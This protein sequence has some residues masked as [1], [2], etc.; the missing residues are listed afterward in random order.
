MKDFK[1]FSGSS[2]L[3][4]AQKVASGL[5]IELAKA[6]IDNFSNG[7][8]RVRIAEDV[9]GK[10]CV[11]LQSLSTPTDENLVET[12]FFLDALKRGGAKKIIG[13]LPWIGYQKQDKAFR[14]GEAVS[15]AV[16]IKTLET[17][18]LDKIIT[19]DLHSRQIVDY[20]QNKPVVLSAFEL[21]LNEIKKFTPSLSK[22]PQHL[23]MVAPDKGAYWQKEFSQK[24]K[25][26]LVTVTKERNKKTSRIAF[27][28]LKIKGSVKDK[29]CI[30][31]DDNLYTGS[32]LILNAKLLKQKGAAAVLCF[33]THPILSGNAPQ[34]LQNSEIDSLT[35]S[36]TIFVP[37][38][39]RFA[40]LK[41][42]PVHKLLVDAIRKMV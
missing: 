15:V 26:S 19:I 13:I 3:P 35:V 25:I 18:G 38:E 14:S 17:M 21:F 22:G 12:L 23:V 36:D 10:T 37:Q 8:T 42:I 28:S 1:F 9:S 5:G 39:K 27:E 32:T 4:L 34:L 11:I 30:I 33:V 20:F 16:V 2:N 31:I 41:I 7:E 24:L 40:K 29:T 6:E